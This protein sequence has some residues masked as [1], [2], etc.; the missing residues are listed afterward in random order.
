MD[1]MTIGDL[2]CLSALRTE[3]FEPI[4]ATQ[5]GNR[6][7]W[8][9]KATPELRATLSRFYGHSMQVDALSFSEAVRS[10]KGEAMNLRAA[11]AVC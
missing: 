10:A 7:A 6:V 4:R 2:Y 11:S 1:E 5:D 3:G 8:V 9:F